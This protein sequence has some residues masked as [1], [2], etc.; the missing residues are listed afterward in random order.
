MAIDP[1]QKLYRAA[2]IGCGSMG[3][4]CMDELVGLVHRMLLPYGHAEILKHHPRTELVAGADPHAG[5]LDDFGQ[6]WGVTRLY[7]DYR[8]MLEREQPEIVSIASPPDLHAQQVIDCAERG[9]KG[10]F[11][12][13]PLTPSLREADAML[14]ACEKHGVRLAINHTRRGDPYM[15]QARRLVEAGEIGKLLTI[16]VTWSGRLFLTGTHSFDIANFFAGDAPTSWVIG[17]AEDPVSKQSV[18]P[19]Q[20]GVDVGGTSY[21]VYESGV[22]A[23]LN[24]RDGHPSFRTEL[25]G[26]NGLI[27][28]D[29]TDA[30]FWKKNPASPFR[31]LVKH[32]F[33]QKM[34]FTPPMVFLLEDLIAA[35]ETDREPMSSGRT[36]RHALSQILGT[37]YSSARDSVKVRFPFTEMEMTP[38]FQWLSAG[39]QP[40]YD[41]SNT[42]A[43]D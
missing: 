20:R 7:T 34:H 15:H 16:T 27:I 5:R 9:V 36:A 32:V 2:L 10:I 12:E 31:E 41:A 11:C 23:Y 17:H 6:R 18:V 8:E 35:M 28:I 1:S 14:A 4:Y 33:P 29:D 25:S 42:G 19:T 39:G 24:G 40:V 43:R 26:T 22:R 3:S 21:V 30:Q 38:P 13:K 37:H